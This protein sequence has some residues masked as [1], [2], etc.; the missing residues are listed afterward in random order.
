MGQ[1]LWQNKQAAF[2]S[3]KSLANGQSICITPLTAATERLVPW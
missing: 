3:K 1:E 2:F